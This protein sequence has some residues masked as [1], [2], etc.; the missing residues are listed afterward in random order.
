MEKPKYNSTRRKRY[1]EEDVSKMRQLR[2]K[3]IPLQ[4]IAQLYGTTRQTIGRILTPPI[5]PGCTLRMIYMYKTHPCTVI[6][7]DFL[8]QRVVIIN[9][10]DD[11]L[12][13][14]FGIVS[15]PTWEDFEQFLSDRCFPES[16]GDKKELLRSLGL[17]DYDPLQ[18]VEKTQGR[19]ADDALW[20]KIRY[21]KNP[22]ESN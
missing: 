9:H 18:I 11:L 22:L 8:R 5:S 3:G 19:T 20:L 15:E 12:H 6:D 2:A 1:S 16:R 14:A 4:K 21:K 10:T 17:S 7:V 13:R